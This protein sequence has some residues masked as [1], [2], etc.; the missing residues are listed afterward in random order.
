MSQV[1]G[2]GVVGGVC[3]QGTGTEGLK[4]LLIEAAAGSEL[5]AR[6]R[7]FQCFLPSWLFASPAEG[8][9]AFYQEKRRMSD[10]PDHFLSSETVEPGMK[11][12]AEPVEDNGIS[13]VDVAFIDNALCS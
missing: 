9:A 3:S 6:S 12:A 4:V 1:Q 2:P 8:A 13:F 11:M 10:L 7:V 5:A